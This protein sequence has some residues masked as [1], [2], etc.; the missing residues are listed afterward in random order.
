VFEFHHH[1]FDRLAHEGV[2]SATSSGQSSTPSLP[3]NQRNPQDRTGICEDY[4]Y[5]LQRRIRVY[6][7]RHALR[8]IRQSPVRIIALPIDPRPEVR[9]GEVGAIEAA[10]D[11][12]DILLQ[13]WPPRCDNFM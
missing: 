5:L 13:R 7:D 6:R 4:P 10:A 12:T 9:S 2:L 3:G 11:K 1:G 8:E